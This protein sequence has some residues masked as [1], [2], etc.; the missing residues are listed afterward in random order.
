VALGVDFL[1]AAAREWAD[2]GDPAILYGDVGIEWRGAGSID[3]SSAAQNEIEVGHVSFPAR[4]GSAAVSA[5]PKF[6]TA[7]MGEPC[8]SPGQCQRVRRRA[9]AKA[10]TVGTTLAD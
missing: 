8:R 4:F 1:I 10:A 2:G 3:K 7:V 6:I 9:A 5:A